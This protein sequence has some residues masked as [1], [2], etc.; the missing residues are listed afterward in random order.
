MWVGARLGAADSFSGRFVAQ[1]SGHVAFHLCCAD[2]EVGSNRGFGCACV[3][4]LAVI[5]C[6]PEQ[7]LDEFPFRTL[8]KKPRSGD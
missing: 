1:V 4:S 7:S 2:G 8:A 5:L 6:G 3:E